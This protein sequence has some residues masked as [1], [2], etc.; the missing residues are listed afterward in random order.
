MTS[1]IR[2]IPAAVKASRFCWRH[3]RLTLALAVGLLSVAPLLAGSGGGA[4]F[5]NLAGLG[6]AALVVRRIVKLGKRNR[7]NCRGNCRRREA[8]AQQQGGTP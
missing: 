8:S 4:F 7:T 5:L 3:R 1:V 6:I 2:I